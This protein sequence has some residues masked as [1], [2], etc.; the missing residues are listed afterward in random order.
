MSGGLERHGN[1]GIP[2]TDFYLKVDA[3]L[4]TTSQNVKDRLNTS[5]GMYLSTVGIGL[6]AGNPSDT[7]FY[8]LCIGSGT[9]SY[10]MVVVNSVG[11]ELQ[12]QND[13]GN[14][15]FAIRNLAGVNDGFRIRGLDFD[16]ELAV[17]INNQPRVFLMPRRQGSATT[18]PI[19]VKTTYASIDGGFAKVTTQVGAGAYNAVK[20]DSLIVKNAITVGGDTVRLPTTGFTLNEDGMIFTVKDGSG[21]AAADNITVFVEGGANIDGAANFVINVAYQCQSFFWDFN[22]LQYYTVQ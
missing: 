18:L 9:T 17:T 2:A 1:A 20:G 6:G 12:R 8:I 7:R 16:S 14:H 21:N 5:S 11:Q 15:L 13:D 22:T 3:A 10:Y 4:T 19:V